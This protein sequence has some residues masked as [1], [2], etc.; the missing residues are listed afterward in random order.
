MGRKIQPMIILT[1]V[2]LLFVGAL[3]FFPRVI[4]TFFLAF[5]LAFLLE[6]L[7]KWFENKGATRSAAVVTVFFLLLVF[8]TVLVVVFFPGLAA[9]LNK[10]V[11]KLPIYV[12]DIQKWFSKL[13]K[14]YKRFS[15]PQN[16]RD[17]I[18]EALLRGEEF[19]RLFLLRLA[20][21]L[22]SFFSQILFL[23][24]VPVLAYYFS[25]DME[26][27]KKLIFT[28]SKQLFR[29]EQEV[30]LEVIKVVTSYLRAQ[31]FSSLLVGIMLTVGL[32]FLQVD[33]AILIGVLAGIFNIIPYFGPVLGA[34]PAV[35]LAAQIRLW[36]ALY[37]ILLFFIVNQLETVV[38]FPRIIGGKLGLHPLGVIFLL[39][40]GGE[41]F[42]FGGI[43]FAVPIGAVLQVIFKYYWKKR[44]IDRE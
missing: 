5:F 7:V 29:E 31:A 6:P 24:L 44:V 41:L 13:N 23:F 21:L 35:L 3:I 9:D 33:L 26:K 36:K 20:S 11:T 34:I 39:L 19:L 28:W 38:I 27:L 42:G 10:A 16:I 22:P 8:S 32:L 40:I 17:V 1:I 4:I 30:V 12:S 25:R 18:D 43:V 14:E 15:L 2:L 37:V